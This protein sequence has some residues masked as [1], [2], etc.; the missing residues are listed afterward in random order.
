MLIYCI[1]SFTSDGRIR[2]PSFLLSTSVLQTSGLQYRV[3]WHLFP[4][5]PIPLLF[6][7]IKWYIYH[8]NCPINPNT[9]SHLPSAYQST[10]YPRMHAYTY[11]HGVSNYGPMGVPCRK[12][13]LTSFLHLFTLIQCPFIPSAYY[14]ISCDVRTRLRSLLTGITQRSW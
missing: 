2:F 5:K 1:A 14:T 8:L 6:Y 4:L 12:I 7:I 9:W 3:A 13:P 11:I 10:D